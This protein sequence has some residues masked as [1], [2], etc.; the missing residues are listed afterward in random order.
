MHLSGG[1]DD[2]NAELSWVLL[3]F[4]VVWGLS[5]WSFQRS[6]LT[7]TM[8]AHGSKRPWQKLPV[9]LRARPRT[10][11]ASFPL[12]SVGPRSH[13]PAQI[14]V[15]EEP[16]V[17]SVGPA[18]GSQGSWSAPLPCGPGLKLPPTGRT[19]CW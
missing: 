16:L 9:L 10:G 17:R 14:Q 3:P 15:E 4:R 19:Q 7:F 5:R 1:S 12:Y 13:R 2:C 18:G 8:T 11:R 6:G